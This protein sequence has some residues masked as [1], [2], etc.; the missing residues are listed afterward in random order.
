MR[1]FGMLNVVGNTIL[2]FAITGSSLLYAADT[3]LE[4]A[5]TVKASSCKANF[6]DHLMIG[7]FSGKDF[8]S[9]GSTSAFKAMTISLTE[10]YSKLSS[11]SVTFSGQPD[12]DNPTL[13]AVTGEGKGGS[14]ATGIGVELLDNTG[15]TIPFNNIK[16]LT[17]TLD[18]GF[19]SLSFLLRYKS[20][21]FPVTSGEAP[22]VL[23]FDLKYQ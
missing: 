13:L 20:T 18:E 23:N 9:V 3:T 5:G 7:T 22:A 1:Y 21:K 12:S 17:F 2:W 15:K 6:N 4:V 10:C 16:P 11:V 14:V 19:T 8:P